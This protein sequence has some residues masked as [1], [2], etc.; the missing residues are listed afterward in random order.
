MARHS[1]CP[2]PSL[3]TSSCAAL[4]EPEWQL[5]P[6][7]HTPVSSPGRHLPAASTRASYPW[8]AGQF[9]HLSSPS[10]TSTPSVRSS[11]ASSGC[12]EGLCSHGT[13]PVCGP[14]TSHLLICSPFISTSFLFLNLQH[15]KAGAISGHF[16][17]SHGVK[18][19][20]ELPWISHA[21]V[22]QITSEVSAYLLSACDVDFS[23]LTP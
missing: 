19:P 12:G 8:P 18:L 4:W 22:R 21:W 5:P 9:L 13:Q 11:L 6:P 14:A 17:G 3:H 2:S 15:Y 1:G 10:S 7:P 23:P 16:C 20:C